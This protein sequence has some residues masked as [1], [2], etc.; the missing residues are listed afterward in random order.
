VSDKSTRIRLAASDLKVGPSKKQ[1]LSRILSTI[2]IFIGLA[3]IG[4]GLWIP[5]QDF[6]VLEGNEAPPLPPEALE[7]PDSE[8]L[9]LFE[10][11]A[12]LA[13]NPL[14]ALEV[15][16]TFV[17]ATPEPIATQL[18]TATIP[19]VE[20]PAAAEIVPLEVEPTATPILPTPTVNPFPPAEAAPTRIVASSIGLDSTVIEV[21]WH[22]EIIDG[23]EISIWDVA[24]YAAG[25]HKNS[26]LPGQPG[27]IVLSGHHN[28]NGEVFRYIV[29]LEP[30]DFITLYADG[31]PYFYQ[32]ENKFIVKDKGEPDDVR[33]QNARWIGP[34]ADQRLTMI[35]CWPYTNNTHRV[36]VISKPVVDA[37]TRPGLRES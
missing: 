25:W 18:P 34:F 28:I 11:G 23:Q 5:L 10:D 20:E 6:I 21:G 30:G 4:I 31:Q 19:L 15:A 36:I 24:D 8:T 32:V 27:N 29:D 1:R 26:A 9:P 2:F 35:A 33:R 17:T 13:D 7:V 3:F 22:K 14:P 37:Q 12:S 16:A